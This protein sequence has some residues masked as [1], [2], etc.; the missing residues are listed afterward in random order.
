MSEK[1]EIFWFL[2]R[3]EGFSLLRDVYFRMISREN[4]LIRSADLNDFKEYV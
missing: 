3:L 4:P 1:R 2:F